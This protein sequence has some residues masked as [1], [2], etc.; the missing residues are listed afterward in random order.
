[1]Q[2]SPEL[3]DA[4][5][6]SQVSPAAVIALL[7]GLASPLAFIG[8]LFFLFPAAA[9]GVGL[10]ALGKIR[11][12]DG[13]LTGQSL[14][15][16]AMALGVAC[17]AAALVRGSVRDALMQRQAVDFTARWIGLLA[18]GQIKE[19]S[20]L[21]SGEGASNLVPPPGQGEEPLPPEESEKLLLNGLASQTLARALSGQTNPGVFEG[22][23]E[24]VYD[25]PKTIVVVK[26][27]VDDAADG[28]HRHV[29]L[30]AVRAAFYET[31][32]EPWRIDRWNTGDA[33]AAH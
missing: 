9:V 30:Q 6:Y 31:T 25:G 26:Y 24:P 13:A 19:A 4:A 23:S 16:F 14:A 21:L 32:G 27:G 2:T 10:V 11:S 22:V 28:S 20:E 3:T 15:R 5:R 33:H 18:D 7:L 17:L 1:L 29:E 8:P 12:S